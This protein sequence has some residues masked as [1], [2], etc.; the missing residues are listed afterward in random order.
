MRALYGTLKKAE[1][2]DPDRY[3]ERTNT[4]AGGLLT[5]KEGRI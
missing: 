2:A 5:G 4:G 1:R 3:R